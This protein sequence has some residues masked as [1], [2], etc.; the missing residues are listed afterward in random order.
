MLGPTAIDLASANQAVGAVNE[1]GRGRGSTREP[2]Q[3]LH[4]T[5]GCF[6]DGSFWLSG[7]LVTGNQS[8]QSEG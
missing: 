7:D 4:G 6:F 5:T 2:V 8:L 3:R 1:E